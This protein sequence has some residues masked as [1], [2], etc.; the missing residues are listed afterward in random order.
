MKTVALLGAGYIAAKHLDALQ[1]LPDIKVQAICDTNRSAAEELAKRASNCAVHTDFA[2]MVANEP[3]DL[4][5]ILLP[6][7]KHFEYATKTLK[8]GKGVFIEKPM[9]L[10]VEECQQ[11]AELAGNHLPLGV[12]HNTVFF[13]CYVKLTNLLKTGALGPLDHVVLT[14]QKGWDLLQGGPYDAWMVREPQNVCFEVG[15]HIFSCLIDLLGREIHFAYAE[16]SDP[17]VLPNGRTVYRRWIG[18]G[19]LDKTCIEV[20]LSVKPG[21]DEH[22]L[23]VRGVGGSAKADFNQ[24]LFTYKQHTDYMRPVDRYLMGQKEGKDHRRNSW[25]VFREYVGHKLKWTTFNDPF[26]KSIGNSIRHF[27]ETDDSRLRAPFAIQVIQTCAQMA[28]TYPTL[29]FQPKVQP[30]K[31]SSKNSIV[32]FGGS[33]FIGQTLVRK[34]VEQGAPVKIFGRREIPLPVERIKGDIRDRSAVGQALAGATTVFHLAR[35]QATT[36]DQYVHNQIDATKLIAEEAQKAG[37]QRLIYTSTIDVYYAGEKGAVITEA[38]SIDPKIVSRNYYAQAKAAEEA[39]LKELDLPL[40]ITRPG[41]VIGRGSSPC[42]WGVGMWAHNRICRLWGE[43]NN[44]LPFVWVED[45]A[46]GLILAMKT[47]NIDGQS[48]NFIDQPLLSGLDYIEALSKA[49]KM[50]IAAYPTPIWRFFANECFKWS[51]K[52]VLRFP[53]RKTPSYH[54]WQ[55]RTQL[56]TYDCDATR[57]VL[58]WSPLSNQEKLIQEGITIPAEEWFA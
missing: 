38:T 54:D 26:S 7:D 41:I 23:E 22:T 45:V 50:K 30:V 43:G 14:W 52:M 27:Y 4:I 9:A 57:H 17:I 36:W 16:P 18:V 5:H 31:S 28:A 12:N 8:A 47:P 34:L 3:L 44:P 37:V 42:P 24:D 11:L 10:S 55:S 20:R 53:D 29:K 39:L 58:G 46:D 56:A 15:P 2:E 32:V 21:F 1:A 35:A 6:P 33:G 51:A 19:Y 25:R 49:S 13:P 48:F 40:V